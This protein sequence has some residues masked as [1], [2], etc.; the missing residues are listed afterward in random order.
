MSRL[1]ALMVLSCAA[2]AL[3]SPGRLGGF[4]YARDDLGRIKEKPE[5]E[6]FNSIEPP[7]PPER[8]HY[9]NDDGTDARTGVR[10]GGDKYKLPPVYSTQQLYDMRKGK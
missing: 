8:P 2:P 1:F 10:S 6:A 5:T 4:S 3:A 9:L 7:P